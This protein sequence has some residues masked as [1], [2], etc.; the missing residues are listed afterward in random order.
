MIRISFAAIVAFFAAIGHGAKR[1]RSKKRIFYYIPG[2]GNRVTIFAKRDKK[3][4]KKAMEKRY[5]AKE[6]SEA[7]GTALNTIYTRAKRIGIRNRGGIPP[8]RPIC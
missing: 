7:S 8:R 1:R 3:E 2:G 5:S 6:I 4:R